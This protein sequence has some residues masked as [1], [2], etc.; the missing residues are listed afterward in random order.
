MSSPT[1][2]AGKN[3]STARAW[4]N[5]SRTIRIPVHL[6]QRERKIARAQRELAARLGRE[7][8]DQEIARVAYDHLI[9]DGMVLQQGM[10]APLW[11]TA[12]DGEEITVTFENQ[13]HTTTAKDGKWRAVEM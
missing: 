11:G 13:K 6:G 12:D 5:R 3:P 2:L 1:L 9:G 7:P 4:I 10:K 8:S